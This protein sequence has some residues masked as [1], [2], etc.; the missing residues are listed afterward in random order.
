MEIAELRTEIS[1][2]VLSFVSSLPEKI[3]DPQ[4]YLIFAQELKGIKTR[5]ATIEDRLK[6]PKDHARQDWQNWVDLE[7]ELKA[8]L[9]AREAF[10]KAEMRKWDDEQERIRREEERRLQEEARKR[11][12]E[13][14]LAAA[15]A[16]EQEG[17]PEEAAQILEEPVFVAPVVLQKQTPKVAGISYR[18]QWKYRIVDESKLPRQFLMPDEKVIKAA[19]DRQ[20]SLCKIPG[21]EVWSEK[22]VAA[23]RR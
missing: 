8:P 12:E 2:E 7:K 17:A 19:V 23:G 3:T 5:I 13:E 11:E 22:I 6:K 1:G 4:S 10:N 16:A 9:L 14:R 21:I 15:I 18:E 20:K